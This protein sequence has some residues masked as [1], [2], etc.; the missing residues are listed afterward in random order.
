MRLAVVVLAFLL[1]APAAHADRGE[2][3][4]GKTIALQSAAGTGV[5]ALGTTG[6]VV[7][8]VS[9]LAGNTDCGFRGAALIGIATTAATI[10]AVQ[11]VGNGLDGTGSLGGTA[12]GAL[13]GA[14]L[15]I[16]GSVALVN[17]PKYDGPLLLLVTAVP[18]IAGAVIGYHLTA[19]DKTGAAVRVPLLSR[20]F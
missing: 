6:V 3:W 4:D 17:G 11:L 20:S 13:L 7:C 19:D 10:A 9:S 1:S 8:L 2:R 18:L 14:G 15:G 16:A 5:V 12:A